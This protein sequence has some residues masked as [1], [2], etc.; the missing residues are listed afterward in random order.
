MG[1]DEAVVCFCFLATHLLVVLGLRRSPLAAVVTGQ[2]GPLW[3][4]R[5]DEQ[6]CE[7]R[8]STRP[9]SPDFRQWNKTVNI[10]RRDVLPLPPPHPE[11]RSPTYVTTQMQCLC[12]QSALVP[13]CPLQHRRLSL[14]HDKSSSSRRTGFNFRELETQLY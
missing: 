6:A 4:G 8:S 2:V 13:R 14:T 7:H 3:T 9:R 10:L 12:V 11:Q 1:G 5:R